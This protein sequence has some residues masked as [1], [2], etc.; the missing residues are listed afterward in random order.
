MSNSSTTAKENFLELSYSALVHKTGVDAPT[1]SKWLNGT[2]SPTLDTMRGV[3][4]DLDMSLL[5]F[6]DAFEER[7]R[8]TI[9]QR[10]K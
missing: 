10:S 5:E 1:W 7:R 6:V 2:R 9:G 8:R 3:A 4:A